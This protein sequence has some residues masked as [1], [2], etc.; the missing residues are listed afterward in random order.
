M[1]SSTNYLSPASFIV[2][3]SR[4]PNV[5]FFTQKVEIPDIS[6]SPVEINSPFSPHYMAQDKLQYADLSLSFLID[7]NME[8]YL[9]IFDWMKGLGSPQNLEQYKSLAESAEGIKSD[10]SVVVTN[11]HKNAN[12]NFKFFNCFPTSLSGVQL[13][14]TASDIQYPEATVSFRYDYFTVERI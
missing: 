1:S 14:V 2:K 13:D 4:L 11:S 8:N 5:E 10:I 3:I 9:E 7:E 12:M 6:S